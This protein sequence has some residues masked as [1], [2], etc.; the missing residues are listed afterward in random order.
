MRARGAPVLASP[1]ARANVL[2]P[3]PPRS[4]WRGRRADCR[5]G[6]A[7]LVVHGVVHNIAH[8]AEREGSQ[9]QLARMQPPLAAKNLNVLKNFQS[10]PIQERQGIKVERN[11][12]PPPFVPPPLP[13]RMHGGGAP[14]GSG[15]EGKARSMMPAD[16]DD[17]AAAAA[18]AAA[19]FMASID[20]DGIVA[21]ARASS[22][23]SQG[24]GA[25]APATF[26]NAV[27]GNPE[28]VDRRL[29]MVKE[30]KRQLEL[31]H[32]EE[33]KL[34]YGN[35][36]SAQKFSTGRASSSHKLNARPYS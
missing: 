20:L 2:P 36:R 29:E 7:P 12:E 17:D 14:A 25:V 9:K 34:G 6:A 13:D 30:R 32:A 33:I 5:S 15:A 35:A 27:P 4:A 1:A 23:G 21:D 3:P 28:I 8:G 19:A 18:A 31:E 11:L 16:D 22:Q 26:R 24:R 10:K